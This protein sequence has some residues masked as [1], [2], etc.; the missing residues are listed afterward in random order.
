M[1]IQEQI[2]LLKGHITKQTTSS[3]HSI[4]NAW[5]HINKADK[6][7]EIDKNMSAFCSITAEEEA[8][9]GLIKLIK[10]RAYDT[11]KTLNSTKHAHKMSVFFVLKAFW[12]H[13]TREQRAIR[14]IKIVG[15]D[16]DKLELHAFSDLLGEN[17]FM[18][19]S[20]LPLNLISITPNGEPHNY[21]PQ[22]D[23]LTSNTET[24]KLSKHIKHEANQRN[25]LLYANQEG[26]PN[27]EF[28][29]SFI[30]ENEKK[31]LIISYLFI[32][33]AQ[34][35]EQQP[36]VGRFTKVLSRLVQSVQNKE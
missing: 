2:Q 4:L 26:L 19:F 25:I 12:A 6:L 20:P 34:H 28:K 36:L 29:R 31:V 3:K 5:E 30:R 22:I 15:L 16:K 14:N 17:H 24:G 21:Q 9:T 27:A 11:S 18:V 13:L 1:D 23:E 32:L 10:E 7:Y 35:K 33:I 8:A